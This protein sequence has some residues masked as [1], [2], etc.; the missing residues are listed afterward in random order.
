MRLGRTSTV[1]NVWL[2]EI[3]RRTNEDCRT[4][5]SDVFVE[6]STYW[7][8]WEGGAAS[9]GEHDLRTAWYFAEGSRRQEFFDNFFLVFNPLNDQ[10][11]TVTAISTSNRLL[12]KFTGRRSV[13]ARTGSKDKVMNSL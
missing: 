9:A 8:N 4:G 10:T 2:P 6:R 11:A 3:A 13:A 12:S 5:G 1:A 7:G